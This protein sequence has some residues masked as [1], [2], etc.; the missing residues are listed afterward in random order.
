[1]VAQRRSTNKI[2]EEQVTKWNYVKSGLGTKKVE[3]APVVTI[4]REAGSGGRIVAERLATK[5]GFD[6]FHQEVV[7]EMAKDAD[8]SL[9]FMETLDERGLNMLDNW[10]AALVDERYLWPDQYM[11]HLMKV[12]GTIGKHGKSVIVGR[13]ANFILPVKTR[14][15]VRIIAPFDLRRRHVAKEF[16]LSETEAERR[17]TLT[18]SRRRS[19]VRRYFNASI[20]DIHHYDMV[21]NTQN[22]DLDDAVAAIEAVMQ[23]RMKRD[24]A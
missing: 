23:E 19:F 22:L 15:S 12:I 7:H 2:V 17:I 21:I 8:I 6:L 5:L 24:T 9:R 20:S 18:E 4:S 1:M 13:G 11:Q 3:P 14:I 16:D 10:I